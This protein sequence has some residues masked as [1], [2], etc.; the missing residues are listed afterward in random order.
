MFDEDF[1]RNELDQYARV[2]NNISESYTQV[3]ELIKGYIKLGK[4]SY[5]DTDFKEYSADIK[6]KEDLINAI[7]I[8]VT[9]IVYGDENG[10]IP[11]HIMEEVELDPDDEDQVDWSKIKV[12]D[13]L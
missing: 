5:Q 10:L 4:V 3:L 6:S 12:P 8:I 13:F 1:I 7:G 2:Y 11:S 9:S